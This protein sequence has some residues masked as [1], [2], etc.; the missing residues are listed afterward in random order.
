MTPPPPIDDS[1]SSHISP[2]C[3][4]HI[5]HILVSSWSHD[6]DTLKTLVSSRHLATLQ[7]PETGETPLHAAIRACRAQD[8][9]PKKPPSRD[10]N[11]S[12]QEA[13]PQ[14]QN[15]D[16]KQ[17]QS[18]L[19]HLFFSGAIW[20]DVDANNETPGC[21]ARR[22]GLYPLYDMCV[23]A[24]VRAELLF[25]LL[26]G[27]QELSSGSDNDDAEARHQSQPDDQE[28]Q[29]DDAPPDSG[30]KNSSS[31]TDEDKP[32]TSDQYLKSCL[33]LDSDKLLDAD[34]N[35][36]M[37]S[38]ETDIM[39]R[40]V[41]AL[42]PSSERGKRI[43]NIGFG[44][45]I[46]DSL[47][48]ELDPSRHHIIEAHPE[49]IHHASK[50]D[51]K[52]GPQWE[53]SGPQEGAFKLHAGKWQD[54]VPQLVEQGEMY[55]AIYFDTFGEDY[56]QLRLFIT[57]YVPSLLHDQGR[58]SFFNGLGA[59]RPL[60]YDV[61]TKV[62]EMHCADAGLDLEWDE[63]HVDMSNLNEPGK[64]AWEG[65][66]RRYWTLDKYRLPTCTFMG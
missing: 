36:V 12:Q 28:A 29:P 60:C 10:A 58:F 47:F 50:P 3:P 26:D 40:S 65:V 41:T 61:Y 37:M 24:G 32:V 25:S 55:D 49:I 39:R 21:V 17:A 33:S 66:R 46:I 6:V 2:E 54:V 44:M 22:L 51:S 45:G 57:E 43:L 63:I 13:Q 48:A 38:W 64:G 42:I 16:M 59:D 20:N 27:Y 7:D 4:Q 34:L 1:Q 31:P 52:F 9:H 30:A 56:S 35:G 14:Q 8:A 11:S 23:A 5:R 53:K 15:K 18:I 62:V 19:E